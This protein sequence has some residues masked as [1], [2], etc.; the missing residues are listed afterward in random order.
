MKICYVDESG[1]FGDL[2]SATS[3]VQPAFVIAGII[4]DH[5]NLPL[6]TENFVQL[7][8]KYYP[9]HRTP[10]YLDSILHEIKGSD[11]RK[12]ACKNSRNKR[13]HAHN[14]LHG[15]VDLLDN[16]D[17]RIIGRAWSKGLGVPF[18]GRAIYTYSVQSIFK[19]G[20]D[21]DNAKKLLSWEACGRVV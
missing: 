14:F 6:A 5:R 7:K 11:V 12:H 9:A 15:I 8:R 4:I 1:D 13:R 18:N 16:S 19:Y 10:Q 2:P 21:P 20:A 17:C 3:P